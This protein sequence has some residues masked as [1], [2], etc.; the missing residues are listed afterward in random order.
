MLSGGIELA[1]GRVFPLSSANQGWMPYSSAFQCWSGQTSALKGHE[2]TSLRAY[3]ERYWTWRQKLRHVATRSSER[4]H[5]KTRKSSHEYRRWLSTIKN[6]ATL[7]RL[8]ITTIASG[9]ELVAISMLEHMGD[10]IAAQPIADAV[11]A[12]HPDALVVWIVRPVYKEVVETYTAVD[13][14]MAVQCI[15]EWACLRDMQIIPRHYDLHV[16]RRVCPICNREVMRETGNPEIDTV[17]YLNYGNLL[18]VMCQ[19]AGIPILGASPCLEIPER[20]RRGVDNLNLPIQFIAVHALSNEVARDWKAEKWL[21]LTRWLL[22]NTPLA[23]VEVGMKPTVSDSAG[24]VVSLCGQLSIL[25]TAEVLRRARLF[26]GVD[27]GPAH[28]AHAVSTPGVILK[29]AYRIYPRYNI[30]SGAYANGK[31]ATLI[32]A[33]GPAANISVANVIHA[34][35]ERLGNWASD[36]TIYSAVREKGVL[37]A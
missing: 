19:N 11:R 7:A 32:E 31:L 28:L 35:R 14:V 17:N 9:R 27:S 37:G 36:G 34:V 1:L 20:A 21:E 29:G 33:E 8:R 3:K 13:R 24:R 25:E 5:A 16:N 18:A 23:V 15:S 6:A 2:L 30:Y 10:I 26:I 4:L 22:D 12:R